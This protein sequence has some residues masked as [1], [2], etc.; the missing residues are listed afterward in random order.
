MR[1]PTALVLALLLALLAVAGLKHEIDA[2]P[3]TAVPGSSLIYVP[4][5]KFLKAATFGYSSFLADVLFVWAIQYYGNPAI[6]DK[7]A[8]F[9]H[10]FSILAELDPGWVDPYQVAALIA[11]YDAR[12]VGLALKM[13]DLGASKNPG[14]WIFPIEAG[15]AAQ[16]YLKDYALAKTYYKKAMEIP[17]APAIA[18]R[19]FANAAFQ[20]MDLK[21]AWET[22][23]EVF[24]TATDP[25][26]RKI[27][28]NHLYRIK[29]SSDIG[30]LKEAL[31]LYRVRYGQWPAD[32][33]RLA[34][35]G[36]LSSIPKDL[37]DKD[38]VYDPRTGEVRTAVIP[39]KR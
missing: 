8:S 18:K 37:D 23:S 15:H 5:G 39:W 38:Y 34:R 7:F 17:G 32:L 30:A 11:I 29:A 13:Y 26:I 21:T 28:S 12:D 24:E 19:L 14:Q 27:A 31:R 6:K 10:I 3:R 20:T 35:G 25:Q 22:W 33:E 4:S 9:E 16:Y 1:G 2:I 36:Y